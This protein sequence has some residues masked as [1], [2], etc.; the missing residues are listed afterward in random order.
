MARVATPFRLV[1]VDDQHN[2]STEVLT[3]DRPP[4]IGD[5]IT[6][7]NGDTV[8][9]WRFVTTDDPTVG[10]IILATPGN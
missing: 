9:V 10:G 8:R 6:L 2:N 7:A 5:E 1:V 3:L 4:D